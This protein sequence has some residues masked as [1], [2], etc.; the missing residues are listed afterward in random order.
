LSVR[1][2]API[3]RAPNR[4]RR[5]IPLARLRPVLAVPA[6]EVTVLRIA[7]LI[8][9]ALASAACAPVRPWQRARLAHWS[10]STDEQMSPGA[11]HANAVNEG[12]T[13]GGSTA[14]SGCGCN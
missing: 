2:D 6:G 13:G 12:A 10:M 11:A 3:A 9:V 14:E 7:L 1:S 8:V 4:N 5:A